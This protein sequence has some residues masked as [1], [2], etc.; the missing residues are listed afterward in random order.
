M[1]YEV[2]GPIIGISISA[3]IGMY[4]IVRLIPSMRKEKEKRQKAYEKLKNQIIGKIKADI[5]LEANDIPQIGK[6]LGLSAS[7]SLDAVYQLYAESQSKESHLVF[8]TLIKEVN[9]T[10][11]FDGLS[12]SVKPSM[13]R[14]STLCEN[15]Q[16]K[17][18][19]ELLRPIVNELENYMTIRD[20]HEIAKKQNRISYSIAIIS[21][22]IGAIGLI[23][24]LS[25]PSKSFI[26]TKLEENNV[27]LGTII[28]RSVTT[29]KSQKPLNK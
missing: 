13:I 27:K 2:L 21:S 26:E 18:D 17:S 20:E 24:A 6:G 29:T 25:G 14:L 7:K 10:E 3:I 5:E 15:S 19:K 1:N 9:K 12:D 8:K 11:P 4:S 23:L 16:Q 22:I 28:H